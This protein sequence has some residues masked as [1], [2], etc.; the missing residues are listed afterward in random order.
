MFGTDNSAPANTRSQQE[1]DSQHE[2][3]QPRDFGRNASPD[4]DSHVRCRP[5]LWHR[6]LV[7]FLLHSQ[8]NDTVFRALGP[9]LSPVHAVAYRSRALVHVLLAFGGA[10]GFFC[11][12]SI[13]DFH[14]L[15]FSSSWRA[16]LFLYGL[17]P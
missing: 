8:S 14:A 3:G 2:N 11:V 6:V 5:F 13:S 16:A 4:V 15:S 1:C 7:W 12:F 9:G 17:M 10:R